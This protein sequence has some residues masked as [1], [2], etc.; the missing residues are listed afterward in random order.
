MK[1]RSLVV[2]L[3]ACCALLMPVIVSSQQLITVSEAV[4]RKLASKTVMPQYPAQSK[5]RGSKGIAV[6]RVD[7]D[8][9]GELSDLRVLEAPDSDIEASVTD[10]VKQ[11]QFGPARGANGEPLRIRSKLTF[12]FVSDGGQFR[13]NNP[14]RLEQ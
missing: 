14:K 8:E 10:A 1:K 7:L 2:S 5:K 11:W 12:Y 9:K 6:V 3:F 13:V 4:L